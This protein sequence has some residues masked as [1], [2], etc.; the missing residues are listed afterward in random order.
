M[1][2]R[3]LKKKLAHEKHNHKPC[4]EPKFEKKRHIELFYTQTSNFS[5][6][7]FQI[8]SYFQF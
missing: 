8:S 1:C 6:T 5:V 2:D 7:S 3:I 4:L